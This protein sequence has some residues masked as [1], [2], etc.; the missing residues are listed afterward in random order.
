MSLLEQSFERTRVRQS[1]QSSDYIVATRDHATSGAVS[2]LDKCRE[3]HEK[4]LKSPD[5]NHM[6][7]VRSWQLSFW[8]KS[9]E[10]QLIHLPRSDIE[11]RDYVQCS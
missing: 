3:Y 8:K 5:S 7:T 9:D 10:I 11:Y 4:R 2:L 6:S 1:N